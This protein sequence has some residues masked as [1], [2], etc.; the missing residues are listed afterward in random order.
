M[1]IY[2][3]KQFTGLDNLD[4]ANKMNKKVTLAAIIVLPI[5]VLISAVLIL[6][7]NNRA[8][9]TLYVLTQDN[10]LVTKRANVRENREVEAVLH[11]AMF[12]E[13][14]L[15]LDPNQESIKASLEETYHLGGDGI[16]DLADYYK[17]SGFYNGL[18]RDNIMMRHEINLEDIHIDLSTH[19]YKVEAKGKQILI[20]KTN[21]VE[22][23]YNITCLL[24]NI[25]DRT[26]LNPHAFWISDLRVYDNTVIQK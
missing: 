18:I 11:I 14:F 25:K 9:N 3:E 26:T 5:I 10:V 13:K 24:Y 20:R 12:Y 4:N 17:E 8:N 6:V 19:P 7:I 21:R 16:K 1:K 2:D 23:R 22:R 15:N